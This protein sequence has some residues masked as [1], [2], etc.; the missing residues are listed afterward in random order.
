MATMKITVMGSPRQEAMEPWVPRQQQHKFC[1]PRSTPRFASDCEFQNHL[2]EKKRKEKF[3]A[4]Q[5]ITGS[6]DTLSEIG[7]AT[8]L[9]SD[10]TKQDLIKLPDYHYFSDTFDK[11]VLWGRNLCRK[12][13]KSAQVT[14]YIC[15][16]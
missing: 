12:T 13:N 2:P 4:A 11:N 1:F 16:I 8:K 3:V 14:F 10:H 9:F 7:V 5:I 15:T 6:C